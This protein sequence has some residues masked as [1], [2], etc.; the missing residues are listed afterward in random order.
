MII[1]TSPEIVFDKISTINNSETKLKNQCLNVANAPPTS[2]TIIALRSLQSVVPRQAPDIFL[3]DMSEDQPRGTIRKID[4]TPN[5]SVSPNGE[6]IAYLASTVTNGEVTQRDLIIANGNFQTQNSISW[7]DQ[8]DSILGW[9]TYQKII[10]SSTLESIPKPPI[11]YVLIDPLSNRQQAIRLNI[12]DFLDK[13]LYDLPYWDGW[14]G[15]LIDPTLKLAVYPRQSKVNKEMFTYA[16]WDLSNNKTLFS[17]ENIFSAF[18]N[19][20]DTYP[21]PSWSIDGTQFTFVGE[22]E[23]DV[24]IKFELFL[25]DRDGDIEQLTNLSSVGYV[26]PSSHSWSSDNSHIA[27]FLFPPQAGGFEHANIA[28][29]NI[30]T[31]DVTDLCLSVN[32]QDF[33]PIWSP[34]GTQFLIVDKQE[35]KPPLVLLVD[36]VENVVFPIAEDVEPIGWMVKP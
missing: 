11:S 31:L 24:P 5:F 33:A 10:I 23:E 2:N 13:S 28:L 7:D 22:R 4:I 21:R 30:N 15:L 19:F 16:L 29:V 32:F 18:S 36:I 25:V 6:L 12:S 1:A 20:K 35:K 34:N 3:M 27:F 8:W 17:L 26:S 9:T 14:Y